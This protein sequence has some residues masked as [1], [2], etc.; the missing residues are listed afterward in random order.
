MNKNILIVTVLVLIVIVAATAFFFFQ[1]RFSGA[2]Q[3]NIENW[4]TYQL[5]PGEEEAAEGGALGYSIDYPADWNFQEMDTELQDVTAMSRI[6]FTAFSD[7]PISSISRNNFR[8]AS[9]YVPASLGDYVASEGAAFNSTTVGDNEAAWATIGGKTV[10][11]VQSPFY[12]T[13]LIETSEAD[14]AIVEEMAPTL[15]FIEY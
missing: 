10:L 1:Q 8:V 12:F 5:L 15:Q 2:T 14:R 11:A 6:S 13:V 3:A 4:K 7:A 9:S